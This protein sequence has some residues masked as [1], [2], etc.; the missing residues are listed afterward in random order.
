MCGVITKGSGL[1]SSPQA[2]TGR[3]A[4]SGGRTPLGVGVGAR[5]TRPRPRFGRLSTAARLCV[6]VSEAGCVL[7]VNACVPVTLCKW[8]LSACARA[9]VCGRVCICEGVCPVC[10]R[11]WTGWCV[12][13]WARV[14]PPVN[15][16]MRGCVR[17]CS[18]VCVY[19]WMRVCAS[20]FACGWSLSR[21]V[22]VSLSERQYDSPCVRV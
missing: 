21:Y 4:G 14:S 17:M 8:M 16:S 3:R 9:Y 15:I 19:I 12:C 2:L 20:G 11:V 1:G 10:L 7:G 18:R 6:G 13:M 5:A 22:C